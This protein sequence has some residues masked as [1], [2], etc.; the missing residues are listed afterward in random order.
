MGGRII[1]AAILGGIALFVWGA[2]AHMALPL[3]TMG[4]ANLPGGETQ[5]ADA[6]RAN[7]TQP[8]VYRLP[9][10]DEQRMSDSAYRD[11]LAAKVK[12]GPSGLLIVVP[13][14]GLAG[15]TIQYLHEGA[16]CIGLALLA[17]FLILVAGGLSALWARILFCVLLAS[18]GLLQTEARFWN[19]YQY[20]DAFIVAQVID[21]VVAGVLLDVVIHLVYSKR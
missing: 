18:F 20:P 10:W 14:D 8:G 17:A 3:G 11:E 15:E 16:V 5:V 9:A 2:I 19:W 6:L 13:K 21:K 1:L 12:A 7:V 4:M